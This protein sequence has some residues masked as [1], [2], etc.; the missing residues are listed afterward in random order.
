[1]NDTDTAA[2]TVR[3]LNDVPGWLT[4]TDR[5]LFRWILQHQQPGDLL[6]LG[7]Y[8]GKT[9]IHMG[10]YL[11][12]GER[13]TVCDLFDHA[14]DDESLRPGARRAYATLTQ[15]RFERNYLA[16]HD[17]LPTVVRANTSE[18]LSHVPAGSCRF[19]HIDASHK[20][21]D[22]RQDLLSARKLLNPHGIV[23]FDD[24]RTEHTPGTAAA[25]WEAVVSEQLRI[26]CLSANRF[27]ATWADPTETQRRLV[28]WIKRRDDHN[29]D[30]QQVLGQQVVRVA[31]VRKLTDPPSQ[32]AT[33]AWRRAADALLPPVAASALRRHL[34][35]LRAARRRRPSTVASSLPD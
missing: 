15:Q 11:R 5:I 22:V 18:I 10:S 29:C 19:I 24:Y 34:S 26:L 35:T 6:E 4:H 2:P 32:T 21:E 1:M 14:R 17:Q 31:R 30:I 23:V 7:T 9:A 3:T 12:A 25:I 27:Y 13:F 16:F 20:Y 33:S 8:L 28:R